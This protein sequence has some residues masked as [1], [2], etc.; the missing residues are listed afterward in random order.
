MNQGSQRVGEMLNWGGQTGGCY[1][2]SA[3]CLSCANA[4][5]LPKTVSTVF[6]GFGSHSLL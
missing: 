4:V 2:G 6:A 5:S 3:V 1:M